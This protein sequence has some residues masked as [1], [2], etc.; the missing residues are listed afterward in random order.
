MSEIKGIIKN[1]RQGVRTQYTNQIIVRIEEFD[2]EKSKKLVGKKAVW[3][4]ASG[5]RLVGKVAGVHGNKGAVRVR[6][7]KGLP[8][9]AIGTE[10]TIVA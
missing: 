10:I 1:Y 6:F 5:K 8:G 2:K 7:D 4:T 3:L 9:Q